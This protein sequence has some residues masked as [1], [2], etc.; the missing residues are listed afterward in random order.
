MSTNPSQSNIEYAMIQSTKYYRII[1]H[2]VFTFIV[3]TQVLAQED[4]LRNRLTTERD[5]SLIDANLDMG[6]F[7]FLNFGNGDS[8]IYYATKAQIKSIELSDKTR[9]TQSLIYIGTGYFIQNDYDNTEKNWLLGLEIANA[10]ADLLNQS[11]LNNKLG[12]LYF[13]WE[14][15]E[16]A[17]NHFLIGIEYA[18]KLK[19]YNQICQSYYG[20]SSVYVVLNQVDKQMLY[21]R[22]SLNV[23]EKNEIQESIQESIFSAAA[24]QYLIIS[25][26]NPTYLDSALLFVQKGLDIVDINNWNHRKPT[27]LSILSSIYYK[28]GEYDKAL[29]TCQKALIIL[30]NVR[31]DDSKFEIQLLMAQLYSQK[32]IRKI[33]Y[34]YL[35]SAIQ[36]PLAKEDYFGMNLAKVSYEIYKKNHDYKLSLLALEKQKKLE[37]VV[38]EKTKTELINDLEAKYQSELKDASIEKLN[39][40]QQIDQL[41]IQKK[42]NQVVF[43]FTLIAIGLLIFTIVLIIIRQRTVKK[44]FDVLKAEQRLN[45]V[46]ME[47]HFFFNALTSVQA[48]ALKEQSPETVLLLS[49]FSKIMRQSLESSYHDMV[50]VEEDCDF[51]EQYVKLQQSRYPKLFDFKIDIDDEI[52]VNEVL[53]PSMILQPFIENSIEHGFKNIDY[54]GKI[55]VVI[56]II[57]NQLI[58]S[59]VDNGKEDITTDTEHISRASQ[60]IKDRLYLLT[61][62]TNKE[63]KYEAVKTDSGSGYKINLTLPLIYKD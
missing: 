9:E 52:E 62:Q 46:R 59:I 39:Q 5:S 20:I 24:Q 11:N 63:A 41:E 13:N 6:K 36:N 57:K 1:T 21:I 61:K 58:I 48:I 33:S 34:A 28:K 38:Y 47:P 45:R 16:K 60:I 53:V 32:G 49:K 19:D 31:K 18:E 7:H 22:K 54:K 25:N 2:L 30:K 27:Y 44:S 56:L 55:E 29:K 42:D 12:A 14:K 10:E 40:Q 15:N 4:S 43:L 35:D 37:Q 17:I 23:I 8:L 50:T 3:S 51:L 26:E